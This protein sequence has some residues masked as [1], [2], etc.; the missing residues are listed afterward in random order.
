M[1]IQGYLTIAAWVG[2]LLVGGAAIGVVGCMVW[3]Y[4]SMGLG[5][6]E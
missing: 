5:D 3:A 2:S 1:G 4:R 6:S